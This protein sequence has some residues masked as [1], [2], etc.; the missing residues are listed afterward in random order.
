[1]PLVSP[2]ISLRSSW[3]EGML[4]L[5]YPVTCIYLFLCVCMYHVCAGACGVQKRVSDPLGLE[6]QKVVSCHVGVGTPTLVLL[7]RASALN[8]LSLTPVS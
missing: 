6:V 4:A 5:P 3:T 7:E 1:M 8:Q 2:Q